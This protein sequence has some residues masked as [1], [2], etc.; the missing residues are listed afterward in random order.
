MAAALPPG[1][2]V[3]GGGAW[4]APVLQLGL[5]GRRGQL[6]GGARSAH[7]LLILFPCPGKT[8]MAAALL[9]PWHRRDSIPCKHLYCSR[10]S[11][12]SSVSCWEACPLRSALMYS[13]LFL[14]EETAAIVLPRTQR[15]IFADV[16]Q[17]L[18]SCVHALEGGPGLCAPLCS[19]RFLLCF[20]WPHSHAQHAMHAG[21]PCCINASAP[22]CA[23][24]LTPCAK[25]A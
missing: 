9:L 22:W 13:T 17:R 14:M 24:R 8:P 1:R 7:T 19:T 18:T 3:C 10:V 6:L 11:P 25:V 5:P 2:R 23:C 21:P 12:G 16:R 4:R 15:G 20:A